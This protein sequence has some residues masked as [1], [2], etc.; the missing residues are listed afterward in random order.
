MVA[1]ALV[2]AR[3][4]ADV[5]QA[6]DELIGESQAAYVPRQGV[7]SRRGHRPH[8][9]GGRD[10]IARAP[11]RAGPGRSDPRA[12]RPGARGDRG[13]SQRSRSRE[14]TEHYLFAGAHPR[15]GRQRRLRLSRRRRVPEGRARPD[16]PARGAVCR[17]GRA[18]GPTP[19]LTAVP[20]GRLGS[21]RLGEVRRPAVELAI[22]ERAGGQWRPRAG[23]RRPTKECRDAQRDVSNGSFGTGGSVSFVTTEGRS[24]S[25]IEARCRRSPSTSSSKG[26]A[27]SSTRSRHRRVRARGQHPERSLID[28]ARAAPCAGGPRGPEGAWP[29]SFSSTSTGPSS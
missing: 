10:R 13:V 21:R 2:R 9:G 17:A 14:M 25:S 8:R 27:S 1:W 15:A 6:F 26:S 29:G 20:S 19:A 7:G 22:V 16:H 28:A 3:H 12:G 5:R 4:V 23:R 18:G 11:G 24:G